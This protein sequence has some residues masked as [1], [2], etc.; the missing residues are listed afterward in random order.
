MMIHIKLLV[1][2]CFVVTTEAYAADK[3]PAPS[4][5]V[6][7]PDGWQNGATIAVSPRT[8]INT[9][10]VILGNDAA[11]QAARTGNTRPWPDGAILGKVV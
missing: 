8:D 3:A 5:S 9:L 10:R 2:L 4:H 6:P 7:Y 1:V 11:V